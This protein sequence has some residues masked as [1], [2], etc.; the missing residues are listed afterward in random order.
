M[1]ASCERPALT[2]Q[3]G[4]AEGLCPSDGSLR[5]SLIFFPSSPKNGG[6]R[7]LRTACETMLVGTAHPHV[8]WIPAFAGMIRL[9]RT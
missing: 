6:Q 3:Q 5:V 4:C 9:R 2:R 7:G 8:R 1:E